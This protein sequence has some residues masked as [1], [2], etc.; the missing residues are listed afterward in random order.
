MIEAT[1]PPHTTDSPGGCQQRFVRP[2][3]EVK[4][5]PWPSVMLIIRE[6]AATITGAAEYVETHTAPDWKALTAA[7]LMR[8]HVKKLAWAYDQIKS[9]H[10]SATEANADGDGRRKP[11]PPR[12]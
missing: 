4:T 7:N 12:Q 3:S 10:G 9:A 2:I 1:S 5:D 6:A 11:A 8:D